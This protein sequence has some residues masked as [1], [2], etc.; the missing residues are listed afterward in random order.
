MKTPIGIVQSIVGKFFERDSHGNVIELKVG[1]RI[2]ENKIIF[3]DTNNPASAFIKITMVTDHNHVITLNGLQEQ[4]FD[5]SLVQDASTVGDV[6]AK[7]SVL[8]AWNAGVLT[9]EDTVTDGTKNKQ[10]DMVSEETAAGNHQI[11]SH[12][13]E[14]VFVLR[15][16]NAVDVN[17]TLRDATFNNLGTKVDNNGIPIRIIDDPSVLQPDSSNTN[18][19][20]TLIVDAAHG[21]L[22]NDTD[23]DNTLSVATFKVAGDTTVYNAA[24][25]ATILNVGTIQLNGNGSYTF[26][27]AANYDGAVPVVSYTTNTG[28]TADLTITINPIDDPSVLQ[29]DSSNTNE[30]T[31]LIVDAAHGVLSNDT[32]IDNTLSVA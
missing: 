19:D 15:S 11:K 10:D 7:E 5:A 14:D 20:T 23:I 28:A 22:S 18:E 6:I 25:T 30:D 26:T 29:P 9:K 31:T 13:T 16:G 27:P 32:D 24:D 12:S 4:L 8:A 3:G 1:D 2:T 21:V 17:S